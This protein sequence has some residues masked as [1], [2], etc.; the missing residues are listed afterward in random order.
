MTRKI[1]DF[2]APTNG[3]YDATKAISTQYV[4]PSKSNH[5]EKNGIGLVPKK[6]SL[7]LFNAILRARNH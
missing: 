6:L 7:S 4:F 5:A 2:L 1:S 3:C